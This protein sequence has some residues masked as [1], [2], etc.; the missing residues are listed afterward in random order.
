MESRLLENDQACTWSN[1][2]L[3]SC[4]DGICMEFEPGSGEQDTAVLLTRV[5]Q[6]AVGCSILTMVIVAIL[7]KCNYYFR[8]KSGPGFFSRLC[9]RQKKVEETYEHETIDLETWQGPCAYKIN[10]T[11]AS[12]SQVRSEFEIDLQMK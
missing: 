5:R 2:C 10:Q 9:F 4:I 12:D 3:N 1:Q 6:V 7:Y 8:P 11:Q